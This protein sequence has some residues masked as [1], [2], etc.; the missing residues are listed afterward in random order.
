MNMYRFFE[1]CL[2]VTALVVAPGCDS[3]TSTEPVITNDIVDV[4]VEA[5]FSTLV[6][7]VQAAGLEEVLRGDGP[8]TVFAP[9]DEAFA[10]LPEGALEGLLADTEAL[11]A[12]LTYHVVAGRIT[13]DQL[14]EGQQVTTVQGQTLTISLGSGARVNDANIQAADIVA[15]NG[16]I[17]VID[18]VLLPPQN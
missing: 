17:H 2:L 14:S 10:A 5:G 6:T 7:A 8:F 4:A 11:T 16:V 15:D 9:T 18:A 12:V 3:S 1:T 13:S